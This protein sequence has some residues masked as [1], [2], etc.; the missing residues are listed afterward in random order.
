VGRGL[1]L[2]YMKPSHHLK[3][4]PSAVT[5]LRWFCG[6]CASRGARGSC[7]RVVA[8]AAFDLQPHPE[9]TP[10]RRL[11]FVVRRS[12]IRRPF[13]SIEPTAT[14]SHDYEP[15][16][17]QGCSRRGL[18]PRP[19]LENNQG[20]TAEVRSPARRLRTCLCPFKC[21]GAM[22]ILPFGNFS[23]IRLGLTEAIG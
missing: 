4:L 17:W 8:D 13:C 5:R 3:L 22:N 21:S 10:D 9:P 6:G 7:R 19:E 20:P 16:A 2:L 18:S 1:W 15:C 11:P 14:P 23:K 12:D